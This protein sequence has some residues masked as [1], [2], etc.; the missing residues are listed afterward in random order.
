MGPEKMERDGNTFMAHSVCVI[1]P[2]SQFAPTFGGSFFSI[3]HALHNL[4]D[5]IKNILSPE[6]ISDAVRCEIIKLY[7]L[8]FT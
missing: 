2:H 6:V 1:A 4:S 7:Y 3:T 8:V 5:A